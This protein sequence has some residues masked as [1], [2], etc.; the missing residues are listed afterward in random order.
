MGEVELSQHHGGL[1]FTTDFHTGIKRNCVVSRIVCEQ[2][3]FGDFY[4]RY[5]LP[6]HYF[7]WNK[8]KSIQVGSLWKE[9][10]RWAINRYDRFSELQLVGLVNA[11]FGQP[12]MDIWYDK[13]FIVSKS[14]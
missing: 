4:H 10:L 7:L 2:L 14:S 3:V 5:Q 12:D 13:N 1:F 9:Q 6:C 8:D 11:P